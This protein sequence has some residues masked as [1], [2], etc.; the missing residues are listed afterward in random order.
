MKTLRTPNGTKRKPHPVPWERELRYTSSTSNKFYR[1]AVDP[2]VTIDGGHKI[3]V[4]YG[5]IG[6]DGQE[7][8]TLVPPGQDPIEEAKKKIESKIKKGYK[9]VL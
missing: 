8:I 5:R 3:T 9:I 6:T 1:V 2:T 4:T 7:H